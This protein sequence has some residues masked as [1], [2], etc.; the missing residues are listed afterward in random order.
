MDMGRQLTPT[1]NDAASVLPTPPKGR[2]R[3]PLAS[4][5]RLIIEE[6]YTQA[7]AA[8]AVGMKAASLSSALRKP[9]V[10]ALRAA[11]KRAWLEN[12]AGKAWLTVA[13][14]A[15]GAASE[16]VRLKAAKLFLEVGGELDRV[17]GDDRA[18]KS[19]VQIVMHHPAELTTVGG[20]KSGVI[21]IIQNPGRNADPYQMIEAPAPPPGPLD[22][23]VRRGG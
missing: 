6:G 3:L 23:A 9:H 19:L 8:Q 2:I 12:E 17:R 10:R 1:P 18:P 21:E 5:I 22:R 11:V 15:S 4:A 13:A 7:D 14:L 16:D 20:N